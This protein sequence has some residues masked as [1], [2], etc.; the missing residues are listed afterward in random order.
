MCCGLFINYITLYYI[1]F[2]FTYSN[3]TKKS[4]FFLFFCS[5]I[6]YR[7]SFNLKTWNSI[8]IKIYNLIIYYLFIII[9]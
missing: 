2:I 8:I 6:L 5:S 4:I 7:V 9:Y 1:N 3:T